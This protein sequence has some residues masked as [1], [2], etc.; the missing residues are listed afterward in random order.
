M[1]REDNANLNLT[2]HIE[3]NLV[4]H[5]LDKYI[6]PANFRE[7]IGKI[8]HSLLNLENCNLIWALIK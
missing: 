2:N 7:K 3:N 5:E 1:I 4:F 8:D 6:L